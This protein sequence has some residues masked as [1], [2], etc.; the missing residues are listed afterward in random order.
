MDFGSLDLRH[1]RL[2]RAI[3]EEGTLTAAADRLAVS[4]PALS[5]QLRDV[6]ERLG[7]ALF[8]R[9][10]RSLVLTGA[11]GRVLES[12]R[13][14]LDEVERAEADLAAL[15][16]GK[17]GTL[18]VTAQCYTTYHWLPP[19]L[20]TF[21]EAWP[22]VEV[23]IAAGASEQPVAA[24]Q[25]RAVDVALLTKPDDVQGIQLAELFNDEVVAVVAAGHPWAQQA[26]IDPDAFGG[27]HMFVW[28]ECAERDCVLSLVADA[29]ARP[30]RI[31]PMPHSTEGAVGMVR[32]GLGVT[33]MAQWAVAPYLAQGGLATVPVTADGVR[34]RWYAAV[35]AGTEPAYVKAF[36]GV[37]K[38]FD[39]SAGVVRDEEEPE[40]A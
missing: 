2:V 10:G 3:V 24:L 9:R 37:L 6:E 17:S 28:H 33:A 1:F 12:A 32:A 19:V 18:R 25:E 11:G 7:I 20:S 15:A 31:T 13:I 35:R 5:H 36:V 8:E 30:R 38:R 34:R 21:C 4:Q 27:E 22:L 29:G 39:I 14:V 23:E 16:A 40:A 26:W